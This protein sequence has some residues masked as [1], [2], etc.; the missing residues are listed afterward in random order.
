VFATK[1][2]QPDNLVTRVAGPPPVT[3]ECLMPAAQAVDG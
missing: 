2:S 1:L 3:R